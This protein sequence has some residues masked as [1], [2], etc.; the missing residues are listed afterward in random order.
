MPRRPGKGGQPTKLTPEVQERI[1]SAIRAGNYIAAACAFAGICHQTY[2][3]WML[4]G[5]AGKSP[6]YV[7]FLESVKKAEADSEVAL[8][9][10]WKRH[11]AENWQAAAAL[12]ERRFPER[13]ARRNPDDTPKRKLECEKVKAETRLLDA[14][15]REVEAGQG[16]GATTIS[17]GVLTYHD[18]AK[19]DEGEGE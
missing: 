9:A 14:K 16:T 7:G 18:Q 6:I 3:N 19:P 13:W 12:L 1:C 4:W 5:E 11:T 2:R 8:V 17:V 10:V 15:L